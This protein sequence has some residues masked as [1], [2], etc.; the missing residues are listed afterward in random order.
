MALFMPEARRSGPIAEE[1][2]TTGDALFRRR[3]YMPLVLVPL[4]VL[5][6]LDD[7]APTSF[8][9]GA[10]LFCRCTDRVVPARVCRRHRAA[11]RIDTWHAAPDS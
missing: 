2:A 5:S 4:F 8:G 10:G 3:S 11:R 1:L 7:R 6:L 9:V